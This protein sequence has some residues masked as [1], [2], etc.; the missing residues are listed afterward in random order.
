MFKSQT[1]LTN[2][3]D[4]FYYSTSSK[5]PPS[6]C[7]NGAYFLL[8]T[9]SSTQQVI[10]RPLN[11]TENDMLVSVPRSVLSLGFCWT[12][13]QQAR[14]HSW[15][16][17]MLQLHGLVRT[18]GLLSKGIQRPTL[19]LPSDPDIEQF[20]LCMR[21]DDGWIQRRKGRASVEDVD[22]KPD[23]RSLN[24]DRWRHRRVCKSVTSYPRFD[25]KQL[26]VHIQYV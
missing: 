2:F 6:I 13:S 8:P 5:T 17:F 21:Q 22:Y 14:D 3:L 10:Q 16:F 20:K 11:L 19:E 24:R 12:E 9:T 1:F 18:S 23:K 26:V 15:S 4:R 25:G 7:L